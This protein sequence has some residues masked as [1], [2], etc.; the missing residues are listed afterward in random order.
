MARTIG[1]EQPQLGCTCIDLDPRAAESDS[2][3]ALAA[4]LAMAGDEDRLA[5]RGGATF[6]S[7]LARDVAGDPGI[8]PSG[9]YRLATATPGVL[10]SLGL[11]AEERRTPGPGEV[12]L[13]V[14]VTGLNF[15]DVL[16][17][18]GAYPGD[19]GPLGGECVGEVAALGP[20]VTDLAVGETVMA[21][22]PG[23]FAS[24]VTTHR[25]LVVHKPVGL[26]I[27]AA[28]TV[29]VAFMTAAHAL[30][31]LAGLRPDER[32]LIHAA[33]G[34]V[35]LAAVQIAQRL[36][37]EV[38]ATAGS[39]AKRAYLESLGVAHVFSSRSADFAAAIL[40]ATGGRGVDVVLNALA[41]PFIAPSLAAL[42]PEG[43]FVEIGKRGIWDAGRVA[44][45]RPAS[46]YWVVDMAAMFAADPVRVG[47]LLQGLVAEIEAGTLS[48]L[49]FEVAA[50]SDAAAAFHRM[51]RGEHVGKIVVRHPA[52]AVRGGGTYLITGGFGGLGL[53]TAEW[54][55]G[56]GARHLVLVGRSAPPAAVRAR[57]A[58]I[59]AAGVQL[60]AAQVD[61]ADEAAMARLF[62]TIGAELPPLGG[63]FHSAGVLDD[64]ALLAQGEARFAR[65][66]APKVRGAWILHRLTAAMPLE[67]FVLYSS[68]SAVIGS[69]GQANHAAANAFMDALAHYRRAQGL[70]ALSINWGAWSE[71]G[72]AARQ[73]V[74]DR[75]A[76]RGIGGIAPH[77]GVAVLA[78]LVARAAAD[79]RRSP[80]QVAVA[81]V[82][83]PRFRAALPAGRSAR[84]TDGLAGGGIS[85]LP[86]DRS[87]TTSPRRVG[88]SVDPPASTFRR[89][90]A[91]APAGRRRALLIGFIQDRARRVIGIA[92]GDPLDTARP[93]HALGLDSLMAVEVRNILG[94]DLGLDRPLPA[95]LVFDHPSVDAL[96]DHLGAL[97]FP[98]DAASA[99]A[100]TPA[101]TSP[102]SPAAARTVAGAVAPPA[103]G[104]GSAADLADLTEEP[105]AAVLMAE[106]A[107][108][109][110]EDGRRRAAHDA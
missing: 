107:A 103:G 88:A 101:P 71:I 84:W 64:G 40:G 81:P 16:N 25:A 45:V 54:L 97:L 56:Q 55:V 2:A 44:A 17:A 108:H 39:D 31:D 68:L 11:R 66:L 92:P 23:A 10:D 36:G 12:E 38:F 85:R 78:H 67:L 41:D 13:R 79:P 90:L 34:G 6:V 91:E 80:A 100:T 94:A 95:S 52:A 43:R 32:V 59:E 29:L 70:P 19:A 93:L 72:S 22:A 58:A 65:V 99:P 89:T 35:G 75:L 21:L 73:D 104:D 96:A 26:S 106:L 37:A 3:R 33:A 15:R 62:K 30:R 60:R 102:T 105:A 50:L 9:P 24:H 27:D 86:G 63:V 42:A 87:A 82:D 8:V 18:L 109:R 20:G 98:A 57:L 28:A 1:L 77:E 61:V 76:A 4:A 74:A 110:A 47:R 5:V 69:P 53:L 83:W 49:P 14:Q 46:G 7:R 48:A 51:A